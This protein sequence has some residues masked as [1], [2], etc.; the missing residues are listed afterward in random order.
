MAT[1][2]IMKNLIILSNRIYLHEYIQNRNEKLLLSD[3]SKY[4][5]KESLS[6]LKRKF[7]QKWH[8]PVFLYDTF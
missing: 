8:Y 2:L 3:M 4:L 6:H 7:P 1:A 5:L